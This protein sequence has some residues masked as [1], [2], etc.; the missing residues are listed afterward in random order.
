MHANKYKRHLDKFCNPNSF[1]K[2]TNQMDWGTSKETIGFP[3]LQLG[4][5]ALVRGCCVPIPP[6]YLKFLLVAI[7]IEVKS[8]A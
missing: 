1:L 4:R 5:G 7:Q 8:N 6:F 3:C 2:G